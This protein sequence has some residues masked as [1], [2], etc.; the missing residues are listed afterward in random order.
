MIVSDAELLKKLTMDD[1]EDNHR[2]IAEVIGLENLIKLSS[3][4]AG[5]G[6][7]AP[8]MENLLRNKRYSMIRQEYDGMNIKELATKYD[9][10]EATVYKVIKD[11]LLK[12]S[13]KRKAKDNI[14]GQMSIADMQG[15]I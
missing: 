6:V 11:M 8:K 1:L 4:F 15:V 5:H 9:V 12:G 13:E 14:P 7:Y 10:C 3:H 2:E